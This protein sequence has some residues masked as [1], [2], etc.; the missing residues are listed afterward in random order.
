MSRTFHH[1]KRH[2]RVKGIQ[3]KEPDLRRLGRA[4]I[5]FA[6]MQAEAEAEAVHGQI[7][8]SPTKK[9]PSSTPSKQTKRP[10]ERSS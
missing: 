3:R 7:K 8:S 6:R 1:G 10:G 2:I 5:E 9:T 4:L